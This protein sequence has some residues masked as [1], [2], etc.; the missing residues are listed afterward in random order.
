[1]QCQAID[2]DFASSEALSC[3]QVLYHGRFAFER[4]LQE[5]S[6]SHHGTDREITDLDLKAEDRC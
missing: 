2:R 4:S 3:I 6:P 5:V 1:V